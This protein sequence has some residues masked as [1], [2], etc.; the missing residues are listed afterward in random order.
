MAM[1]RPGQSCDLRGR[2][3]PL[4]GKAIE[5]VLSEGDLAAEI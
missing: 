1:P 5:A 2:K 3:A 4:L